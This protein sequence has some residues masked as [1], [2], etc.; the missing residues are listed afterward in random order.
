MKQLFCIR[1]EE[2]WIALVSFLVFTAL[3]AVVIVRY[4]SLFSVY[5]DSVWGP[6]PSKFHVSGFDALVYTIVSRWNTFYTIV[7]R[8]PLLPILLYPLYLVNQGLYAL[9]G[10]NCVQFVVAAV[11]IVSAVY[12]VI[13]LYRIFQE[14][15]G[16]KKADSI[17]LC[18]LTFSFAY[19]MLSVVVP[20]HFMFSAFLLT[21]TLYISGRHIVAN[22]HGRRH[23]RKKMGIA[24]TVLLFFLTGGLSLTN[25][26]K[27]F[28]AQWFVNGRSFFRLAN[29]L[30]GVVLPVVLL[31]GFSQ[32]EYKLL[33]VPGEKA[34]AEAAAAKAKKTGKPVK[35]TG[36][37]SKADG[38]PFLPSLR[39]GSEVGR[40]LQWSDA[41]TSRTKTVVHN[42]FGESIQLH[43]DH[44][45]GDAHNGR[46][47]FVSYRHAYQYVIE[48]F[49]VLL[50]VAGI[51][52]GRR[53]RFLWLALSFFAID[54]IVHLGFG[55]AI[56]EVYI[57]GAHWLFVIPLAIAYIFKAMTRLGRSWL[58]WL[59]GLL[60]LWLWVYN[61][62]L[63]V[64]YM[65]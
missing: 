49:I 29:L 23:E 58:R 41:T 43:E 53:E 45:L 40:F 59:T 1:R 37:K 16:L 27:V 7:F 28:L 9:T 35:K 18:A 10:I 30:F 34:R 21:L 2:R 15:V 51:W 33:T 55:F 52:F 39:E 24:A 38:Q 8:H 17:V 56:N 13:F 19:M 65:M 12:T 11:L 48:A 22:R 5:T 4:H 31:L 50:F 62:F 14:V 61:G 54:L 63:F 44:L 64:K 47:V 32:A 6:F 25:G 60:A 26:V 46:P 42:L 36:K 57:T 3:T 20:E